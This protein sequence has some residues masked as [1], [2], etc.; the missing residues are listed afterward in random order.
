MIHERLEDVFRIVLDDADFELKSDDSAATIPGW[1]SVTHITLMVAIEQEFRIRFRGN[2]L[3][4]F[5][6]VGELETFLE[7]ESVE[8]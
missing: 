1:D 3:A 7:R 4:E 2:E 6:D 8:A 5:Q